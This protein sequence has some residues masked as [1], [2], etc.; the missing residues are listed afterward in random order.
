MWSLRHPT[1]RLCWVGLLGV[2]AALAYFQ[3]GNLCLDRASAAIEARNY[4]RAH[5]WLGW[6]R[7]FDRQP[8]AHRCLLELKLARREANY[9]LVQQKLQEAR[10]LNAP[11][12]EVDRERW[13][14]MAQTLQFSE[15][16]RHWSTL[17]NDPRDDQLEIFRGYYSW[18]IVRYD[19]PLAR[20]TLDHW[21]Q[22]FPNDPEPW[23]LAGHLNLAHNAVHKGIDWKLVEEDFRGAM[24]RDPHDPAVLRAV[25][26]ACR[27][28]RKT[29]EAITLYQRALKLQTADGASVRGL[30]QCYLT[31]A[32]PEQARKLLEEWMAGHADDSET[33]RTLGEMLLASGE[34]D[35]A[36]RELAAVYQVA[37]EDAKLAYQYALALRATGHDAEAEPLLAFYEESLPVLESLKELEVELARH[38]NSLETRMK[39]GD[40]HARYVSRKL[41]RSWYADILRLSPSYQPAIAALSRLDTPPPKP[42]MP[43]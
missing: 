12:A 25:A 5:S 21:K 36:C 16:Q 30:A 42:S 6:S 31:Q 17:L 40:I 43:N 19:V 1:G 18:A 14:S 32:E 4:P 29:D 26:D 35:A 33:R 24:Q 2:V 39:L 3:G 11:M 10:Q 8:S 38:P 41:A 13:L 34:P 27:E 15:V 9:P 7:Q 28:Q 22:A 23:R 20:T 37:P